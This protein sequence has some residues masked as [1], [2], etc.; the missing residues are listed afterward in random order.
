M[1]QL[2]ANNILVGRKTYSQVPRLLKESV[3][4]ILIAEGREDLIVEEE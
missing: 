3:A 4:E 2:W 1:A